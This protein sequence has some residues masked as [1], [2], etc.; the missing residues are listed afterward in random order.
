MLCSKW[1]FCLTA[2][3]A[4]TLSANAMD[5]RLLPFTSCAFHTWL[6]NGPMHPLSMDTHFSRQL[7]EQMVHS[8][9]RFQCHVLKRDTPT[10]FISPRA[11]DMHISFGVPSQT[12]IPHASLLFRLREPSRT[13]RLQSRQK[14]PA[15]PLRVLFF[16]HMITHDAPRERP[17][18]VD[19][20]CRRL[21]ESQSSPVL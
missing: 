16:R 4:D 2:G 20:Q 5:A 1:P 18:R 12:S 3:N 13:Y 11:L 21:Q 15:R 19:S 7:L 14:G 9:P 17:R 8:L 6:Q 10:V